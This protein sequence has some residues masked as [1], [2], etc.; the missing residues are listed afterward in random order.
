[1]AGLQTRSG[2]MDL[3]VKMAEVFYKDIREKKYV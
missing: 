3:W 1:M 2:E